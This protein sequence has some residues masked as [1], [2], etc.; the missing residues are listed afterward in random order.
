MK[1][2]AVI[3][4]PEGERR[5]IEFSYGYDATAVLEAHVK[6]EYLKPGE[7]LEPLSIGRIA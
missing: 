5:E 7:T 1:F 2:I 3:R 4:S 6:A